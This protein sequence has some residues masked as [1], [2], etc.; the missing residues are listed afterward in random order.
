MTRNERKTWIDG[1]NPDGVKEVEIEWMIPEAG[2]FGGDKEV[3]RGEATHAQIKSVAGERLVTKAEA[4]EF[5]AKSAELAKEKEQLTHELAATRSLCRHCG[6]RP[7]AFGERVRVQVGSAGLEYIF[8]ELTVSNLDLEYYVCRQC[9]SLEFFNAGI[10]SRYAQQK[11]TP[12][13][14]QK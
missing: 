5:I 8:G 10:S 6:D 7:R 12:S 11:T 1:P 3:K 13:Q 9:G 14:T 4:E 2:R